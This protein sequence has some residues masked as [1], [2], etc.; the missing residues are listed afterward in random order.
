MIGRMRGPVASW[1]FE[2]RGVVVSH[3]RDDLDRWLAMCRTAALGLES[4]GLF[5]PTRLI[6]RTW[7]DGAGKGVGDQEPFLEWPL[8]PGFQA[9][10]I[11]AA[12]LEALAAQD[13]RRSFLFPANID[14][15]G[16]GAVLGRD[17]KS[18]P[19][20]DL[21][22]LG[23]VALQRF[24]VE[25]NT[26]SDAWLPCTL[27]GEPQPDVHAANAPRLTAALEQIERLLGAPPVWE[28]TPYAVVEKFKLKNHGGPDGA[29]VNVIQGH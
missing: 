4:Q 17:G 25:V 27:R 19:V 13:A 18:K 3:K 24:A 1:W 10:E 20:D 14:I 29:A 15:L 2:D 26:Q 22:W 28:N 9:K 21:F 5:Q 23:A 7:C 8:A 16:R 12:C 6:F 11:P